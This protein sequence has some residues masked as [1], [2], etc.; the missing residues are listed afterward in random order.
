MTRTI[1]GAFLLVSISALTG[2]SIQPS[3]ER[4]VDCT[5]YYISTYDSVKYKDKVRVVRTYTNRVGKVYVQPRNSLNTKWHGRW[6][7]ADVLVNYECN[8]GYPDGVRNTD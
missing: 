3:N 2:C 4:E 5:A 8:G 7:S 1:L 6:Q